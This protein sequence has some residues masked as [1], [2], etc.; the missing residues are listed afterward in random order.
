MFNRIEQ[1][2]NDKGFTLIELLVVISIIAILSVMGITIYGV[3][4]Q[5]ARDGRRNNDLNAIVKAI[6]AN[7]KSGSAYYNKADDTALVITGSQ[8]V[9]GAVP[10]DSTTA[11][12]CIIPIVSGSANTLPL[13]NAITWAANAVNG[14]P[15]SQGGFS[16]SGADNTWSVVANN[17]TFPNNTTSWKVCARLENNTISCEA[18]AQ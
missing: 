2:L 4:Q 7:K 9:G 12:Y 10:A 17:Y 5:N 1:D 6:E 15:T 3:A 13:D 8:F 16:A 14:C 18:S 11:K